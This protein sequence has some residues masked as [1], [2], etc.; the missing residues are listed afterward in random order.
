MAEFRMKKLGSVLFAFIFFAPP[1]AAEIFKCMEANG[2]LKLQ[3]FPCS[4]DSIGSVAT[5]LPPTHSVETQTGPSPSATIGSKA[6]T[7]GITP[8]A[9][10]LKA[11]IPTGEEPNGEEPYLGMRMSDVREQWGEPKWT[12]EVGGMVIWF[13]DGPGDSTRGVRFD[14]DGRVTGI[15]DEDWQPGANGG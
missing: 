1:V 8:R 9:H 2:L 3:N 14:R 11:V 10:T 15:G 7:T 5:A 13:Y 12:K 6:A 4:V